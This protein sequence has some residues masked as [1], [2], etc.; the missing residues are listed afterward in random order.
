MKAAGRLVHIL[1][2]REVRI[3]R[4]DMNPLPVKDLVIVEEAM[5]EISDTIWMREEVLHITRKVQDLLATGKVQEV[6]STLR[7]LMTAF[8]MMYLEVAGDLIPAALKIKNTSREAGP[9]TAK[10]TQIAPALWLYDI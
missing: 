5:T 9:L 10:G 6:L 1:V 7:L 3:M 4:A 2:N 8:E